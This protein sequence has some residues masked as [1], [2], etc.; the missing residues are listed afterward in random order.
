MKI[1]DRHMLVGPISFVMMM[2]FALLFTIVHKMNYQ[3]KFELKF[4]PVYPFAFLFLLLDFLYD[5]FI[6]TF[7]FLEWPRMELFTARLSRHKN[8]ENKEYREFAEYCCK[9][10]NRYDPGHC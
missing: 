6:G 2:Y 9:L 8:S 10:L 4:L 1:D 3:G 5:V 7:L